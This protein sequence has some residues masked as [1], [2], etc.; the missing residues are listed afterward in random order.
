M[1]EQSAPPE[2]LII[3]RIFA[4]WGIKGEIKAQVITDFPDRF[5]HG[6]LVY[7]DGLPLEIEAS[8]S[9]KQHLVLK[10]ATVDTRQ[11][12][13]KLRGKD[14]CI[15]GTSMRPLPEDEY[16]A[17]QLIDLDVITT[18]GKPVGRITDIMSTAS[19]D[20]YVVNGESGEIPIPAIDDVV[21]SVDLEKRQVM[22]EAIEGLLNSA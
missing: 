14:L 1:G 13:E 17:F 2:F 3:G 8:R 16:Y 15:P 18:E 6:E 20:V 9:H 12:A 10:L 11:D 5:A 19:N 4:P 22:I 21:K 7:V